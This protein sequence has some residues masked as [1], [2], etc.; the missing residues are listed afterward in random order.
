MEIKIA[1]SL[2]ILSAIVLLGIW[3]VMLF[4]AQPSGI[5]PFEAAIQQ[6]AYSLS[7]NKSGT[8]FFVFSLVSIAACLC[9]AALLFFTR[10]VKAAIAIIAIHCLAGFFIYN[11]VLVLA[12]ALPLPFLLSKKV[13][14]NA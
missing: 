12:I 9:T 3:F 8:W 13:F 6:A 10:H 14:A 7:P 2:S 1:G 11:F 5:S 4:A